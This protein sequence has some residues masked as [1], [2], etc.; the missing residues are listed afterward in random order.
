MDHEYKVQ[1]SSEAG[2]NTTKWAV[3]LIPIVEAFIR[4]AKIF[5]NTT[6]CRTGDRAFKSIEL[7]DKGSVTVL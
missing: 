1:I 3:M 2:E 4:K 7:L 6:K 5:L